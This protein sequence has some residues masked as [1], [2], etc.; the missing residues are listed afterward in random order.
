MF[1]RF[2]RQDAAEDRR[3]RDVREVRVSTITLGLEASYWNCAFLEIEIVHNFDQIFDAF[4][5]K[6][7]C[8]ERLLDEIRNK[9]SVKIY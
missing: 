3:A 4:K 8:F 7:R 5:K 2:S 1:P 6:T 9:I